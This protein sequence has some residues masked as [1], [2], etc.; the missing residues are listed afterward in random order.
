MKL[1]EL[2]SKNVRIV[3]SDATLQEAARTMKD[4]DIGPLPVLEGHRL[5]GMVTDRD[6]AVRGVAEGLD[7]KTT[8]VG[9]VITPDV[10]YGF[11]DQEAEEAAALMAQ[12]QIR[13]LVV[14][15]HEQRVVGMV[16]LGDLATHGVR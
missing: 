8:K 7:P 2:M 9:R 3:R 16:S 14:L 10:V 6:L 11:E 4:A 5:I 1:R 15:D 12:K 13:R